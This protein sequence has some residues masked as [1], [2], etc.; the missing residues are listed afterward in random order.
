VNADDNGSALAAGDEWMWAPART[1]TG[2][3]QRGRGLG[4]LRASED[5][6]AVAALVSDAVEHDRLWDTVDD[7]PLYLARLAIDCG[8]PSTTFTPHLSSDAYSCARATDVLRLLA[9]PDTADAREAR[10]AL[11]EYIRN[12]EHWVDV[13]ESVAEVWPPSWWDDLADVARARLTG[14][15]SPLWRTAPW[16]RWGIT[17]PG[18]RPPRPPGLA[19]RA[20]STGALLALLA[21]PGAS[22]QPKVN[23][24]RALS[25]R[26]PDP[27]LIPLVPSLGTPD[28]RWSLVGLRPVVLRLGALAVPAARAWASGPR[29]WRADLGLEVLAAHGEHRDLPLLI[30]ELTA[31]WDRRQWCGPHSLAEGLARFGPEAAEAAP[32]LRRLWALTP[33]SYERPAYLKALAVIAPEPPEGARGPDGPVGLALAFTESL[34]DC[35]TPARLLACGSAPDLPIVRARLVALRDDPMEEAGVRGAARARLA[36]FPS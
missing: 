35:E 2:L 20:M 27:A 9:L 17:R 22:T 26:P 19:E 23:A 11:R 4:A 30:D 28:D 14:T 33:H 8:L 3:I 21:D 10:D 32:V 6:T 36:E 31:L 25:A 16:P 7:R 1:L 24:L 5:P 13:L 34:W 18:A 29:T 12:G 15:D